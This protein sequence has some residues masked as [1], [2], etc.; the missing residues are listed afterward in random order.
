MYLFSGFGS[1]RIVMQQNPGLQMHV[2]ISMAHSL[3]LSHVSQL[4]VQCST[5]Y[6]KPSARCSYGREFYLTVNYI[7]SVYVGVN[8]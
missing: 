8:V 2:M 1:V 5:W 7:A 4:L 3:Y 6:T